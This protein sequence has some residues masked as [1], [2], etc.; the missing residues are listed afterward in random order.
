MGFKS[1]LL[2]ILQAMP[3]DE[4]ENVETVEGKETQPDVI[5]EENLHEEDDLQIEADT[6]IEDVAPEI[7]KVDETVITHENMLQN[8]ID[9]KF[10][11]VFKLIEELNATIGLHQIDIDSLKNNFSSIESNIETTN[12]TPLEISNFDDLINK[13]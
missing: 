10:S 2:E 3:D 11:E 13:I 9:E 6:P 1:Q 12:I 4:I 7:E 5:D 8:A